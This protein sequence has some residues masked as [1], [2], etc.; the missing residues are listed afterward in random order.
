MWMMRIFYLI[1]IAL[2]A[3]DFIV[4]RHI[5][6]AFEEIPTFYALYGFVACVVLVVIAKV[7]RKFVMRDES[8]Y[9][10]RDDEIEQIVPR[11][12]VT[13]EHDDLPTENKESQP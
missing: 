12:K 8:Y 11:V 13:H 3:A 9:D 1:C 5:Y 6:L 2:V 10:K 7:I 4:H